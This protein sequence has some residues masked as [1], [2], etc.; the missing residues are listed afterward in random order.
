MTKK[1]KITDER[2]L[3]PKIKT[4]TLDVETND[5]T[6]VTRGVTETYFGYVY[7][8]QIRDLRLKDNDSLELVFI[9]PGYRYTRVFERA[10]RHSY[11]VALAQQFVKDVV[12]KEIKYV[13]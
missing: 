6:E 4:C 7:V 8:F 10:Y 12:R 1:P 11:I 5:D 9:W 13:D 2:V 3:L